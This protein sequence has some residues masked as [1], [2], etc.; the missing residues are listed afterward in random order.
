MLSV[1]VA[2]LPPSRLPTE[3]SRVELAGSTEQGRK[4]PF[5]YNPRVKAPEVGKTVLVANE[6]VDVFVT[7]QNVFAFDLEIQDLSLLWVVPQ[8]SD[9]DDR[10]TGAPFVTSPLPLILPALSV[11]TVRVTGHAPNAG[12][13]QI[14]GVNVPLMDGSSA[15]F[16]IPVIDSA[17]QKR[18]SKH[19]SRLQAEV[20]KTKRQ[21]LEARQSAIVP[22][23]TSDNHRWLECT[24]VEEQPL[25]WIKKTTLSHGTIM[26]YNGET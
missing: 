15:E 20:M 12:S 17:E 23:T 2:S 5:L 4:D 1:E 9:T 26:L 24:V 19:R 16:L 13:L 6:Q 21:G 22:E 18:D 7:L 8:R 11:Q 25:L 10:T 14:R 3:R